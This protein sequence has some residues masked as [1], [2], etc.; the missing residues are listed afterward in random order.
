MNDAIEKSLKAAGLVDYFNRL[1]PSHQKEYLNWI[2]EA[3]KP[4]TQEKR[5]RKMIE[6]LRAKQG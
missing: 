1:P 2:N 6:M 4:E 5:I 3:K